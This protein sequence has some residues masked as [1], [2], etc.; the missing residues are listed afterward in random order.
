MDMDEAEEIAIRV[1]SSSGS[2]TAACKEEGWRTIGK[3]DNELFFPH[4]FFAGYVAGEWVSSLVV[5]T[6]GDNDEYYNFG[7]FI[8]SPKHR[9]Q[10]KGYGVKTWDYAWSKIPES[11]AAVSVIA[12]AHMA[13]K[14]EKYGLKPSWTD[15]MFVFDTKEICSLPI[16]MEHSNYTITPYRMVYVNRI[17][18]YDTSAFGYARKSLTEKMLSIPECEGWVALDGD[19]GVVGYCSVRE[20][21]VENHWVLGPW[22]ANNDIIAR[23]LLVKAANFISSLPKHGSNGLVC[24]VP[25]INLEAIK[26]ARSLKEEVNGFVRMFAKSIPEALRKN[27]ATRVFGVSSSCFGY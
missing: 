17:L 9:K 16:L 26:L 3:C 15:Y 23:L 12:T 22:Y 19:G 5:L 20:S 21:V 11:C 10:S 24:V 7:S 14:F 1:T 25:G 18:A 2:L 6:Y 13:P 4:G 27:S 8:V